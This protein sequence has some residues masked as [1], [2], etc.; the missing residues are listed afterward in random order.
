MIFLFCCISILSA[1]AEKIRYYHNDLNGSPVAISDEYGN[2]V[3]RGDYLPYGINQSSDEY[4]ENPGVGFI[5]RERI[6]EFGLN[7]FGDRFYDPELRRFVSVDPADINLN[8]PISY[9]RY[10][11]AKNNPVKYTDPEG[12]YAELGVEFVSVGIGIFSFS[13][14]FTKGH[15]WDAVVDAGTIVADLVLM[16]VPLAPGVTSMSVK[17]TREAERQLAKQSDGL[18]EIVVKDGA[19]SV[20]KG[21]FQVAKS[22]GAAAT[23]IPV[24]G[25]SHLAEGSTVSNIRKIA[26]GRGI[27]EVNRLVEQYGGKAK[28]WLKRSGEADVVTESGNIR[29]AEVHWYEAHG[30]GKVEFKVKEWLD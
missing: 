18:V 19:E 15:Y 21:T 28:N 12:Q 6:D 7:Y 25:A 22:V 5:G 10:A 30:V 27:R 14:N 11:Y 2:I 4:G 26:D 1:N 23:R 9:N 13:E 16:V 29:R 24:R 17:A 8:D 3:W 20:A